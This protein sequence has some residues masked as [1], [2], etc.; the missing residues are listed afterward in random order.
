MTALAVGVGIAGAGLLVNTYEGLHQEHE[1][2]QIKK[3]LQDPTYHI[4]SEFYE[5][6]EIARQMAQQGLPQEVINQQTNRINQNQAAGIDAITKS[7]R[8]GGVA[9]VVRQGDQAG[10]ALGAEDAQARNNNQ[11]YFIDQNKQV[12]G[13]ELD[14]QQNDV[15]D[16]YTRNFNQMQADKGAGIQNLNNAA[17]GAISLGE[18]GVNAY[19]HSSTPAATGNPTNFATRA[20]SPI[21]SGNDTMT[22]YQLPGIPT[23]LPGNNMNYLKQPGMPYG[24]NWQ[25]F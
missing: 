20:S 6:R 5:N 13:Q 15:Y 9:S 4:P 17:S 19:S 3:G 23:Q 22:G 18:M 24:T 12:A 25:Q 10:E 8:P 1:A 11:R 14:K 21:L 16:K 7:G 2:N